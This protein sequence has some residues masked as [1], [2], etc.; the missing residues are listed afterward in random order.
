MHTE[1]PV[2]SA[3]YAPATQAVHTIEELAAPMLPKPPAAQAVQ[4]EVPVDSALYVPATQEVHTAAP[5]DA[6]EYLPTLHA[7]HSPLELAPP[8]AVYLPAP[9]AVQLA[10]PE[11]ES[12]Y[13][14]GAQA[15][16]D[17]PVALKYEP[18]PHSEEQL[19][20]P[21][22]LNVP[23]PH[24]V[25]AAIEVAPGSLEYVPAGQ[26]VQPVVPPV[27]ALYVPAEQAVQ[28]VAGAVDS[29]L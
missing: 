2:A 18:A 5:A 12:L 26:P 9:Q 15:T 27:S 8:R 17:G 21:A 11:A 16:Q 22:T 19:V 28:P 6:F 13:V 4:P 23:R 20:D 7:V 24:E 3:L 25:H 14:P 29:A 1:V 10:A